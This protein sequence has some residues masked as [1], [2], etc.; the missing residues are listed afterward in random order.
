MKG[1]FRSGLDSS[2]TTHIDGDPDIDQLSSKPFILV[3]SHTE[4]RLL[5][6]KTRQASQTDALFTPTPT[7]CSST[8]RFPLALPVLTPH[9]TS[10]TSAHRIASR[11]D[12]IVDSFTMS[13][14]WADDVEQS[15]LNEPSYDVE[16]T[17]S[18]LDVDTDNPLSS[19]KTFED[20]NLS[21]TP[22]C[23]SADPRLTLCAAP[24][25]STRAFSP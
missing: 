25:A 24:K 2:P 15:N 1:T 22:A 14:S 4:N 6:D 16:V 9:K 17:V 21:V 8:K 19:A 13:T 20:L 23:P 12:A 7:S 11:R 5:S 18:N 3:K 10:P